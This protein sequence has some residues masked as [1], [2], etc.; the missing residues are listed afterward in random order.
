[1]WPSPAYAFICRAWLIGSL[2]SSGS[3][4][5]RPELVVGNAL[6]CFAIPLCPGACVHGPAL[7][8]DRSLEPWQVLRIQAP[9]A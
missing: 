7:Q 9:K 6:H 2:R 1:M 4:M 8:V 5:T 3:Q